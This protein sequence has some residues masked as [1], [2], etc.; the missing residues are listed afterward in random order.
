MTKLAALEHAHHG[1]R[2][3]ALCPAAVRLN[4]R[5]A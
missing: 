1:I 3:N 2:V 4:G 5:T